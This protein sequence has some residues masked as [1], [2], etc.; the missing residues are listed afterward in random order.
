[1]ETKINSEKII[2]PEA[3][4][5]WM[6]RQ[7]FSYDSNQLTYSRRTHEG[8]HSQ[9][10]RALHVPLPASDPYFVRL[11]NDVGMSHAELVETLF[12]WSQ[13]FLKSNPEPDHET[14][15]HLSPPEHDIQDAL[16]RLATV[17]ERLR[18]KLYQTQRDLIDANVELE[19]WREGGVTEELLRKN[20][21]FI[22]IGKGCAIVRAEDIP[23]ESTMQPKAQDSRTRYDI[24]LKAV[25]LKGAHQE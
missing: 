11:A 16:S 7:G 24:H 18:N 3:L 20:N 8:R 14:Q 12:E 22:R 15:R 17:I 1:M 13:Q 25:E 9:V 4:N 19:R 2:F 23:G 10:L 21:G 5:V 6:V